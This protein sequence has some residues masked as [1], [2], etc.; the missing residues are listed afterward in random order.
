MAPRCRHEAWP[1]IKIGLPFS[2]FH[3]LIVD[4]FIGIDLRTATIGASTSSIL[5]I[6][7][8]IPHR[9]SPTSSISFRIINDPL[10]YRL[11]RYLAVVPMGSR[12]FE[13][14]TTSHSIKQQ[15]K[16]LSSAVPSYTVHGHPHYRLMSLRVYAYQSLEQAV[17]EAHLLSSFVHALVHAYQSP[18][19]TS[20]FRFRSGHLQ[21]C[22]F[23]YTISIHCRSAIWRI[24]MH[25]GYNSTRAPYHLHMIPLL[26]KYS[27]TVVARSTQSERQAVADLVNRPV[28][29]VVATIANVVVVYLILTSLLMTIRRH[30]GKTRL[31][32]SVKGRD[33]R[34][35][36]ATEAQQADTTTTNQLPVP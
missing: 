18:Q 24:F 25:A 1:D 19:A 32:L 36:I 23:E 35:R 28:V 34:L 22:I 10:R 3:T 4:W 33:T 31:A 16:Q 7:D 5:Y 12:A 26:D 30:F 17:T 6:V 15:R 2:A 8:L 13:F 11:L 20:S 27:K 29:V 21:I 14:D 9:R